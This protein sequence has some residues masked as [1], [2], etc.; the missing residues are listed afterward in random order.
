ME[1]TYYLDKFQQ[2]LDQLDKK[3]FNQENL[4]LKVGV[5]V[6]SVVLKIQKAGWLNN[7]PTAKPFRESV[8]F[9]IWVS[10]EPII[11][12]KLC[13]NIHALKMRE[14]N[15]Y[16]IKSLDFAAAF[17]LRFKAFEHEWPNV[18]VNFGPLTL[19]EGWVDGLEN[20]DDVVPRLAYK[21]LALSPI[22]DDL[23]SERKK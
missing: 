14:L 5:W 12:N 6:D 17:R 22:I 16:S 21:F 23:L 8:F 3:L 9:S 1:T 19:M 13:Y 18:S 2:C 4:E 10:D 7:S 20:L 11:K 15:G